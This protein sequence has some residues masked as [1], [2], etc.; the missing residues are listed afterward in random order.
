MA[1]AEDIVKYVTQKVVEYIDTPSDARKE[2]R[3]SKQREPW[4][5]RWFGMIPMSI[6]M[7]LGTHKR[8]KAPSASDD[9]RR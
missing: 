6:S 7:L 8:K 1:K 9:R 4:T 3:R 5:T 2:R